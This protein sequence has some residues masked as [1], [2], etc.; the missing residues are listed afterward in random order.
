MKKKS[1]IGLDTEH[2][3]KHTTNQRFHVSSRHN[4]HFDHPCCKGDQ[5]KKLGV[6]TKIN[7]HCLNT[8]C[9]KAARL[10]AV[11]MHSAPMRLQVCKIM[12]KSKICVCI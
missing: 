3:D 10:A 5:I 6:S 4:R 11:V 1:R 8:T 9:G 2:T 7:T 12:K